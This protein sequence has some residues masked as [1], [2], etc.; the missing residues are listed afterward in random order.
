MSVTICLSAFVEGD[1]I[2]E[3]N[4]WI[5]GGAFLSEYYS[6]YDLEN[7]QVGLVKAA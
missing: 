1:A 7:K 4:K 5:I 2:S 3:Q 6:I